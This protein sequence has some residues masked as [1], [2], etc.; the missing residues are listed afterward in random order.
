[1]GTNDQAIA[2]YNQALA[3]N[4][5]LPGAYINRGEIYN[6]RRNYDQAI[7]DFNQAI[8]IDPKK[9]LAYNGRAA[10]YIA[11]GYYDQAIADDNVAIG[12]DPTAMFAYFNRGRAYHLS[13]NDDQSIASYSQLIQLDPGKPAPYVNRGVSYA[14]KSEYEKAFTD[15]NSAL[16]IDPNLSVAINN[17]AWQMATCPDASFRDG[18]KAVEFAT[19]ACTLSGWT[20]LSQ[21][22][23]LAAAY[24]E[25]GDFD[26]AV[27]LE[28][29]V[30]DTPGLVADDAA[31]AKA[32]VVLYQAHQPYHREPGPANPK[33][34]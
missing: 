31:M 20:N 33:G 2:D 3:I 24:A 25:A 32:R 30:A 9:I 18:S 6:Q 14:A 7:S 13:G 11:K 8:Q 27:K 19:K 17:L 34:H 5:K 12:L 15:F 29:L 1:M 22:D 21:L 23:T 28:K 26:N 10:A 4:P 16:Q